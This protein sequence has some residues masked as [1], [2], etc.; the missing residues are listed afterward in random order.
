MLTRILNSI[1][2]LSK[3]HIAGNFSKAFNL[4]IWQIFLRIAK[5]KIANNLLHVIGIYTYQAIYA[6]INDETVI[7]S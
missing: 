3:Y 7:T 1:L 2:N 6:K 4:A 5:F